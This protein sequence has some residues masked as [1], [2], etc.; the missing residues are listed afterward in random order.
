MV[1]NNRGNIAGIHGN[2]CVHGDI[3][4]GVHGDDMMYTKCTPEGVRLLLKVY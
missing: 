2:N 4:G 1:I 3:T